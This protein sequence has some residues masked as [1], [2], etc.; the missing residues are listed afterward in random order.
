MATQ[1]VDS[2]FVRRQSRVN[3]FVRYDDNYDGRL[4]G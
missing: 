4:S 1:V 2:E 3:Y